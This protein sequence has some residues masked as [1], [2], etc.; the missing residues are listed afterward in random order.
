MNWQNGS[1]SLGFLPNWKIERN[2][3]W[4]ALSLFFFPIRYPN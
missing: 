3:T 4:L 2:V 1:I